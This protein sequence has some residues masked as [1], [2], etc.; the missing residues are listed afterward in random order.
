MSTTEQLRAEA[1]AFYEQGE[2]QE[3]LKRYRHLAAVHPDDPEVLND[4]GTVCFA[5]GL[6]EESHRYYVQALAL[7]ED[8]PEA[9]SNLKTL[10]RARGMSWESVE[11]EVAAARSEQEVAAGG[12]PS[13]EA[14]G[15]AGELENLF[16]EGRYREAYELACRWTEEEPENPEAW[17]DAAVLAHRLGRQ[18]EAVGYIQQ[19]AELAPD[20]EE[21]RRNMEEICRETP[22]PPPSE[23][24]V[25]SGVAV[26]DRPIRVLFLERSTG[27]AFLRNTLR[28]LEGEEWVE[29]EYVQISSRMGPVSIDRA[30]VVWLEWADMITAHLTRRVEA[31][32]TKKTVC[33]LHRYEAFSEE[34]HRINWEVVD[35]LVFV[36]EHIQ[37]AFARRFPEVCVPRRVIPNGVDLDRFRPCPEAT[38]TQDIAFLAHLN[39]R[40]N[41]PLVLQIA[42][43]LA[44]RGVERRVVVGGD[45]RVPE[46]R[47]YFEYMRQR[48]ELADQIV[49]EGYI[50]EPGQWLAEK[51]FL[52]STS[53][54]EGHPCN[55]LEAMAAGLRP[56]VHEFPGAGELFPREFLF[57]T[58]D[59]AVDMLAGDGGDPRQIRSY[60]EQRYPRGRQI[61]AIRA[62]LEALVNDEIS[63]DDALP[64]AGA[65]AAPAEAGDPGDRL[66][67]TYNVK[68]YRDRECYRPAYHG[69]ARAVEEQFAP[70][71][72]LE[73]GCGAGYMVEYFAGK[74]PVLG[75]E[76]SEAAFR[77]MSP[78]ARAN[79]VCADLTEPPLELS[80]PYEG[81]VCIEVAEHLPEESVENFLAW[82]A[83][84]RWALVTAA[85]PGQGGTDHLN[86]Q[87][88]EYWKR[89]F[90]S[91][92][93]RFCPEETK[94][95]RAAARAETSMCGWVVE[96][97]M[98]FRRDEPSQRRSGNETER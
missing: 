38:R 26:S 56:V 44:D 59:E 73:L 69:F 46:V 65:T 7:E 80:R 75:V 85:P 77:V 82:F 37:Q 92:G 22:A 68:W 58:V 60:V 3:A 88:P 1:E 35:C 11:A 30:D 40:K 5:S 25:G 71:S 81:V 63:R 66:A 72:L 55:V 87:P 27:A 32:R 12:R 41:L 19:A 34:P 98:F 43:A 74:I 16:R 48:L 93:F 86:E 70:Q 13:G 84:A 45:W 9:L 2:M 78:K 61:E 91:R 79:A 67:T 57:G 83:S 49:H 51:R 47:D 29:T 62:L 23:S 42:R 31:L 15:S 89:R 18:A 17:N 96:N 64:E 10:S 95:W 8:C 97:A 24:R 76:G 14:E 94:R 33:R 20:N 39:W 90:A 53:I 54:S 50:E 52:L 36:A 21:V 6:L 4:A 28:A